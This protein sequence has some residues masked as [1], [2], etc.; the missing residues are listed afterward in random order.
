MIMISLY[1]ILKAMRLGAAAVE[2]LLA[3]LFAEAV[4]VVK[5]FF[6]QDSEE[7][8]LQDSDGYDLYYRR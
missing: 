2:D 1:D 3:A 5:D 8:D 4:H 6:L 7:Y